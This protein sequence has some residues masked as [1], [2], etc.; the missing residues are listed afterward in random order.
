MSSTTAVGNQSSRKSSG[1]TKFL[2]VSMKRS[3]EK[4]GLKALLFSNPSPVVTRP[5][6][7]VT[8]LGRPANSLRKPR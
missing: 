3:H 4:T 7:T 5:M 8:F 1:D 6:A 2:L